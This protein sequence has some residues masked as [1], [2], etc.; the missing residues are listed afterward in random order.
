MFGVSTD[1][2]LIVRSAY[3]PY[4]SIKEMH[5]MPKVWQ[6]LKELQDKVQMPYKDGKTI[7]DIETRFI[8]EDAQIS[9][10]DL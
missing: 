4:E 3:I 6:E 8:T 5:F 1:K 9:I 10:F 2:G 7:Q